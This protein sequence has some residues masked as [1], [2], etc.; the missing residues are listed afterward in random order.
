M[1]DRYLACGLI[2]RQKAHG[3]GVAAGLRQ[4]APAPLRPIAQ[5]RVRHLDHEAS[6]V[7][8]QRIGA[9]RAAMVEVD[10]DL[11]AATYD[12]VRFSPLDIGDKSD[13]ARIVLVATIVESSVGCCHPRSL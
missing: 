8:D 5:Q 2:H 4:F 3:D 11:Q 13:T 9:D 6:A 12:V 10:E 1:L 7:P